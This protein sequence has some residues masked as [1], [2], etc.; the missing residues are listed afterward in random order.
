MKEL[1]LLPLVEEPKILD[2]VVN[3]WKIESWRDLS[4]KEHGPVFYAGGFPWSVERLPCE[5]PFPA[6]I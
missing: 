1:V 5:V 2:D 6:A 4:K 3:T